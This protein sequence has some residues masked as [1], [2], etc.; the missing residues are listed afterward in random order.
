MSFTRLGKMDSGI[1]LSFL[2]NPWGIGL[3][4]IALTLLACWESTRAPWAPFFLLYGTLIFIIPA[5]AQIH[6][7]GN[8]KNI[9]APF[10]KEITASLIL[11]LIWEHGFWFFLYEKVILKKIGKSQLP[12]YSP[13]A[14]IDYS[15]HE[16]QQR[17]RWKPSQTEVIFGLYVLLWAPLGESWFYFAYVQ[18]IW[19]QTFGFAV[20]ICVMVL[21]F[22]LRHFL[23]LLNRGKIIPWPSAGAFALSAGGSALILGS[24]YQ[25][26]HSL[27][28][29]LLLHFIS[30]GL[31]VLLNYLR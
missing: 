23:N 13:S 15:L 22:G 8:L 7:W 27:Y 21:F 12:F 24:L 5:L 4:L 11:L 10:G 9:F 31:W 29:L 25:C 16:A 28:P 3:I 26:T 1:L 20:S 2:Q 19:T 18:N 6:P 17:W 30:N 14:A